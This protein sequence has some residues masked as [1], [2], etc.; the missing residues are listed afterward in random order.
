MAHAL[1][2]ERLE[3]AEGAVMDWEESETYV[4]D[5][6]CCVYTCRGLIDLSVRCIAGLL[7]PAT[8]PP[9]IYIHNWRANE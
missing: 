4:F 9:A 8:E 3:S 5:A 1:I 7:E 6:V 2:A